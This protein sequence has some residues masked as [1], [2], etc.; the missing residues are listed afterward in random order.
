[1]N[2]SCFVGEIIFRTSP[3]GAAVFINS[4]G[5][6]GT[7]TSSRRFKEAIEPIDQTSETLFALKRVRFRYKKEIDPNRTSQFGLVAEDVEKA[8]PALVMRD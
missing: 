6:L 8:D 3:S 2:H 4:D 1:M 7:M 5:R